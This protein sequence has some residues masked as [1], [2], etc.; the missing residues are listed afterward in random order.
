[1]GDSATYPDPSF[2]EFDSYFVKPNR[3]ALSVEELNL[4]REVSDSAFF[5][6]TLTGPVVHV[7]L[8]REH[9]LIKMHVAP[10]KPFLYSRYAVAKQSTKYGAYK[11]NQ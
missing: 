10:S 11:S 8:R 2:R 6:R 1:M 3:Y 9:P 7:A 5:G 4:E